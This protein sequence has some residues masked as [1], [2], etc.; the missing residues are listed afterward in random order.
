[1]PKLPDGSY[2]REMEIR[3]FGEHRRL[4]VWTYK[5]SA[6]RKVVTRLETSTEKSGDVLKRLGHIK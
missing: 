2:L 4:I 3:G 6:L 1:M 5:D